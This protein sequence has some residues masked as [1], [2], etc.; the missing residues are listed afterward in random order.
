M[1]LLI[2]GAG[3][4]GCLY[5]ALFSEAG[6]ETVVYARG[7]RLKSLQERGLIYYKNKKTY[8]ADINVISRLEDNDKY[9]FIFLTVRENQLHEALNEL[10]N[11]NSP[12]IVTMVNSL[13]NY[14][15]WEDICGEGRILPAFPG[16]GGSFD[17]DILNAALTPKIIQRT[18]F[19][20][21]N[22]KETERVALLSE[23]LKKSKIPFH[24]VKDMHTWQLCHLSLVVPIADAYYKAKNPEKAGYNRVLMNETAKQ[25][26]K[27]IKLL[28]KSGK[29]I[30]PKKL[31][32]FRMLPVGIIST[33]LSYVFKSK[34]GYTFMYCHSIKAPD[35]MQRLHNE[36]YEYINLLKQQIIM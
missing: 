6:Y 35:E 31:N 12:T 21:I 2:Y 23:I 13:E 30:S 20:E 14:K 25:I 5:A 9:D 28:H 8:K 11:N 26:K 10:A 33:V 4:I 29:T 24:K 15:N 27:N 34:F 32:L 36:F 1:R 16:A 7:N 18:T 3:V 22:G 17:D 19:A